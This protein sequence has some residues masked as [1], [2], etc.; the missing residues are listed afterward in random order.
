[1][2]SGIGSLDDV[3]ETTIAYEKGVSCDTDFRVR[4]ACLTSLGISKSLTAFR[5]SPAD[6]SGSWSCLHAIW[7][8]GMRS[9][10]YLRAHANFHR[11]RTMLQQRHV[12][13]VPTASVMPLDSFSLGTQTLWLLVV[14]SLAFTL[15]LSQALQERGVS[16]Q[17]GTITRPRQ[18]D[19]LTKTGLDLS[20]EKARAWL[21]WKYYFPYAT[22][23]TV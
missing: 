20:L 15:L 21:F 5:A 9:K 22:I 13:Q 14:P 3:Y 6:Q 17:T 12:R 23:R 18:A 1:M 4:R 16:P 11:A 7:L 2:G 10:I 8:Q 19:H